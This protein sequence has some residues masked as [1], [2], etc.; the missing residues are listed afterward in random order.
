MWE[1]GEE[2]EVCAALDFTHLYGEV[3]DGFDG[4]VIVG[5]DH[6]EYAEFA[7]SGGHYDFVEFTWNGDLA[8]ADVCRGFAEDWA[9]E[10]D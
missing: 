5:E 6:G 2:V 9:G 1:R 7:A 4:I 10:N 3:V 8:G